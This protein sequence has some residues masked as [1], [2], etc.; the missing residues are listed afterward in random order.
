MNK[1]ELIMM[2]VLSL[3]KGLCDLYMHG[4]TEAAC[5]KVNTAFK[6][7]LSDTLTLQKEVFD[8]MEQK[9]WYKIPSE[10]QKNIDKVVKKFAAGC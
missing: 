2:D 10:T 7:A 5:P 6:Q 4:A 9:G 8:A 3:L 1:D